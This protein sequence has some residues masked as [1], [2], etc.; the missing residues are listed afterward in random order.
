MQG[1]YRKG[2]IVP[3]NLIRCKNR[4]TQ[5]KIVFGCDVK[6]I[7]RKINMLSP[8]NCIVITGSYIGGKN[9]KPRLY[10][11]PLIKDVTIDASAVSSS[12]MVI[13]QG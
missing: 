8:G 6:I 5:H 11:H 12:T 9:G 10:M 13:I 1:F 2:Q 4:K 7:G 3:R